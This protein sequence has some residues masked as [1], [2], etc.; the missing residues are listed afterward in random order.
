M[1]GRS[2][3][4]VLLAVLLLFGAAPA[5][6]AVAEQSAATGT[7]VLQHN[8]LI[9]GVPSEAAVTATPVVQL[10][11][12]G[13]VMAG[14]AWKLD[15][16]GISPEVWE[17]GLLLKMP[18]ERE[19]VVLAYYNETRQPWPTWE[20]VSGS[21]TIKLDDNCYA[22]GRITRAGVYAP[23]VLNARL[24]AD[25]IT[26]E[27]LPV[28]F[29]DRFVFPQLPNGYNI[30]IMNTSK[31]E[32]VG[33]DGS[34]GIPP[35]HFNTAAEINFQV[36]K[37]DDY[38]Y[39]EKM[40]VAVLAQTEAAQAKQAYT[41]LKSMAEVLGQMQYASNPEQ[42]QVALKAWESQSANLQ[43]LFG[44]DIKA[45]QFVDLITRVNSQREKIMTAQRT[46]L[47]NGY[48]S[49]EAE[50]AIL[51]DIYNARAWQQVCAEDSH[52]WF[53]EALDSLG[54]NLNT[55]FTIQSALSSV[56]DND[57]QA[58]LAHTRAVLRQH[59]EL[60]SGDLQLN[61]GEKSGFLVNFCG[62]SINL[63]V[64]QHL[65]WHSSDPRVLAF[66]DLQGQPAVD[67]KFNPLWQQGDGQALITVGAKGSL[68]PKA[69]ILKF[70][71]G[72]NSA[73]EIFAEALPPGMQRINYKFDL[74]GYGGYGVNK[75]EITS[76]RLPAGLE[77]VGGIISGTTLEYGDFPFTV[78][79]KS[80]IYESERSYV[81][82]ILPHNSDPMLFQYSQLWY[83][84]TPEEIEHLSRLNSYVSAVNVKQWQEI[85]GH[86]YN[87]KLLQKYR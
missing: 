37:D 9:Q 55:L 6:Y 61:S 36:F 3:M 75:W 19:G 40:M 30:K 31:P 86:L 17:S 26:A 46:E 52:S 18:C 56:L 71:V 13:I 7:V 20:I 2:V 58:R 29:G 60:E 67:G 62:E 27:Q 66:S 48:I 54:W 76:G 74:L 85:L 63:N 57:G 24:I 25:S 69:Y 21:S 39:T 73:P 84:Y 80:S 68:D 50:A 72:A 65:Q 44:R 14:P 35:Y 82:K 5:T 23:L 53:T 33:T 79:I 41:A 42:L 28:Q 81:L 49:S 83:H 11:R 47:L 34:V 22:V 4:S 32:L 51:M 8:C 64:N 59:T 15:T 45:Q 10:S 12:Q 16:S 43:R 70:K 77:L 38:A 1:N 78:T 87:N